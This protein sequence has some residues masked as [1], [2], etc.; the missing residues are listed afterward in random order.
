MAY[1]LFS[2]VLFLPAYY[3]WYRYSRWH[4]QM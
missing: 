4:K 3:A 1:L 2:T